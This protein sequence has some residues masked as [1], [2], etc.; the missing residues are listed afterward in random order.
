M[1]HVM[2]TKGNMTVLLMIISFLH[3]LKVIMELALACILD[4]FPFLGDFYKDLKDTL[5]R[6]ELI[7][8]SYK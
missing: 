3:C 7:N 4:I 5:Q 2:R 6:C 8:F 1:I